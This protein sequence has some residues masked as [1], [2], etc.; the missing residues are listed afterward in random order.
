M[1]RRLPR[2]PQGYEA[3]GADR[4]LLSPFICR[5]SNA[6]IG[7]DR[8]PGDP[9]PGTASPTLRHRDGNRC[10]VF[11]PR[12]PRFSLSPY[13]ASVLAAGERPDTGHPSLAVSEYIAI[14]GGLDPALFADAF[15]RAAA[16]TDALRLRF[17]VT[18]GAVRRHLDPGPAPA[19]RHLDL[20]GEPGPWAAATAWLEHEAARLVAP[21]DGAGLY[22][23]ALITLGPRLH[24]WAHYAHPL[25]LDLPGLALLRTRVAEVYTALDDGRPVPP[26][27]FAPI[28]EIVR[29]EEEIRRG[30]EFAADRDHWLARHPR[31]TAPAA[32]RPPARALIRHHRTLPVGTRTALRRSAADLG[33]PPAAPV[34]AAAALYTLRLGAEGAAV[35]GVVAPGHGRSPAH[36]TPAALA[37][38]LHV[39]FEPDP[40]A[41]LADLV[42][43]AAAEYAAADRHSRYGAADLDADLLRSGSGPLPHPLITLATDEHHVRFGRNHGTVHVLNPGTAG[44]LAAVV[45][46]GLSLFADPDRHD[47]AALALHHRRLRTLL[48]RIVTQPGRRVAESDALTWAERRPAVSG[49]RPVPPPPA[50]PAVHLV[51]QRRVKEAPHATAVVR[52]DERLTY[53]EL[54]ARANQLAHRLVERG[55]RRGD[56][57][58][59]ALPRSTD[60]V[61]AVLAV[62]KAGACY[63]PLDLRQPDA[64]LRLVLAE[65]GAHTVVTDAAAARHPAAEGRDV[66]AIDGPWHEA[67][68]G[69]P[70]VDVDPDDLAYV[71]YTSGST[72]RPKGIGVPHRAV[73]ALAADRRWRGGGHRRV[74]LHSPHSFDAATYELWTPLLGG[75][76]AVIAPPGDLGPAELRRTI[77]EGGAT[78]A[79]VT[80][81]L[82][83]V[84]ADELP[85]CFAGMREVW[86]GGDRVAPRSC[87]RVLDHCPGLRVVNVYGPTETTTFALSHP[88]HGPGLGDTV[89]IGRPMDDTRAHVLDRHLCPVPDGV[90]G[91]LYLAGGGLAR[92]YL[93]APGLTAERFVAD[94]FGPPGTRMYRT[95]DV[96]RRGA[97]GE[98][99]FLGRVDDQV[100]IRGFRI[101]PGE[102]EAALREHPGVAHAAVTVR[103]DRPGDRQLVGYIVAAD[104]GEHD[105]GD[106]HVHQVTEWQRI[107]DG[108]YGP[109]PDGPAAGPDAPRAPFGADFTGWNSSYDGRPIPADH[110][111]EWRDA[112]VDRIRELRPRRVLEIGVGTGLLLARL[113]PDC[114]EY[115]GTDFSAPAIDALRRNVDRTPG[116]AGRVHLRVGAADDTAGLPAGRFD[117]IVVNSVVQYF[118]NGG[119]LTDVLRRAAGL[120]APGGAI[121][122]GDVRDLRLS[123][124][125]HTETTL[126]RADPVDGAAAL[127]TAVERHIAAEQELMVDPCYFA[128]LAAV[129]P[130]LTGADVRVKRGR[131]HNEMSQYRYD[132]V[133][134]TAAQGPPGPAPLDLV[135]GADVTG[136]G[137]LAD[138]LAERPAPHI[139]L[140]GVPNARV[141]PAAA[142]WRAL[143]EE[144][145]ADLA[146]TALE[147]P[148]P[149]V[150]DPEDLYEAARRTGHRT[151][152][153][154]AGTPDGSLDVHF[155]DPREGPDTPPASLYRPPGGAGTDPARHTNSPHLSRQAGAL[156]ARVRTHLAER[157]PD[158]MV[159]RHIMALE[160]LP[161][162]RNGKVDRAALPAPRSGAVADGRAPRTPME[163]RLCALFAEILGAPS[164]TIDDD[165]F[166]LGGHSLSATRLA[167][168]IR[169]ALGI[170]LPVRA[171]FEAP[172]VADLVHRLGGTAARGALAPRPRPDRLPLSHAQARLW[173]LYRLEGPTATYNVP[174]RVRLSGRLDRDALRAA[175]ADVAA[176]HESLRTV[177]ADDGGIPHQVVLDGARP[178][179]TFTE[180]TPGDLEA[181]ADQAARRPFAIDSEPPIRAA[182]F[183]TA[184][185]AHVLVLVLHHIACDG[186]S[187]A[188]LGRDLATAYAARTA[189]GAPEWPP[190]PVQYADYTLWQRD[191]LGD[192][193]G[194][195]AGRQLDHW[196]RT[197]DG[198]P[199]RIALP[200]DRPHPPVPAHHGDRVRF[201]ITAPLHRALTD[202]AQSHGA[203][204][205]MVLHA[206][207]AALLTR[208]GA[209]TDIPI[210]SPIAGRTDDALDDLV[211][212]FV[213]TLVLRT[214][215]SGDPRFRDLL[216]RV[217]EVAL[218][219]HAH[220]DL[221][222]ERLVEEIRPARSLAH[223]PLFQV[224]LA[225]QNAPAVGRPQPG[226]TAE[227]DLMGTGT[228]RFDLVLSLTEYL[229]DD[230]APLGL[231]GIAEFGTA[232]FDRAT[233]DALVRRLIRLLDSAAADPGRRIGD[234][235]VLDPDERHRTLETWND[236]ARDLPRVPYP[237]LFDSQAART[238]GAP[239]LTHADTT[240]TYGE[241]SARANRLARALIARG[242]GPER[243]VAIAL[244]RSADQV[245]ALLAVLA[246][247]A[248]Y[249]PLDPGQPGE[250]L[251]GMLADTR[252][253]L[254]LGTDATLAGLPAADAPA[255]ALDDIEAE[256]AG[257]PA[258]PVADAE[259][260]TPLHPAHPAYTIFT[261]GSTGR[262]KGVVV[263]HTGLP[264]LAAANRERFGVTPDSRVLQFAPIGFDGAVWEILGAL[265]AGAT[266]VSAAADEIAPG[267]GLAGLA[268]RRR[269]THATLPPAVLAAMDPAD[270]PGV[271]SIISSG[272]ELPGRLAAAWAPG[273]RLINGYGPTETTVCATLS[274]PLSGDGPP[275]IG[276][277][278]VDARCYVLDD[279]LAPMPPGAAGELYVAGPGLARG[280]L[281]RPGLTAARFVAD[282]FGRP[283]TRMYRTGDLARWTRSG[284]LEFVG[285]ADDQVKIR[286]FR[287]EPGEVAAVL[288]RHPAVGRAA[289]VAREDRPG[290][291]RLVAY[292]VP[293]PDADPADPAELRRH[294]AAHLPGYLTPAAVV[295]L[296]A[297]PTLPSGKLDKAALPAPCYG[298]AT[299]GRPPRTD[300]EH[301]LCALFADV[302][303]LSRDQVGADDGFFDLG[304]HSL[305]V[306]RLLSGVRDRTGADL[307][308]RRLFELQTVAAIAR[309]AA[310]AA[311]PR[312]AAGATR[313]DPDPAVVLAADAVLDPRIAIAAAGTAD[314]DRGA[315]PEHI[316]LTGATGFLGAALLRELLDRTRA[317]VH[318]LVRAGD[319]AGG[320]DRIRRNMLR[321]G[322]GPGPADGARITAVPGDLARPLLG[323]TEERF[324]ELAGRIDVIYHNGARVSAVEPYARLRSHNV[325]GTREVI[326]LAARGRA[327]P[328]HFVSTAAVAVSR[329]DNPAVLTEDRR[330][331]ATAVLP[332]G[333][334]AGKWVAEELLGA[335]AAHGLPVTV[336]RPGRISGHSLTGIGGTDDTL[337]HLVRAMV[338]LGAVPESATRDGAVVDLVP[339]DHVA[340]MVVRISRHPGALGRTHHLTCP[341]PVP[342]RVLID[343]L[344]AGGHELRALPDS[345]WRELLAQ[346][347]GD[348]APG[349]G[350][351]AAALLSDVLP[352]VFAFGGLRFDR[353]NADAGLTGSGIAAPAVDA[354]LL[355]RYVGH[356]TR[357]GFF[358]A[359]ACA[360]GATPAAARHDL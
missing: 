77:T 36:R 23:H 85:D 63:V 116:L 253:V 52:G 220:Q 345:G 19:P 209:G 303:G 315:D 258:T 40:G 311:G 59:I 12:S 352:T 136:P 202:L 275:P 165:F 142:A 272:E 268:A 333:Y 155:L 230:G 330:P 211:G 293:A 334:V 106:A 111:H 57:V 41:P 245:A 51:F 1:A 291:R 14:S 238:P 143:H 178:E 45:G 66:L 350:L 338:M 46:D 108:L 141:A 47:P 49:R 271:S 149:G 354:G 179:F 177:M 78:A 37:A 234:L 166:D 148:A 5:A 186:W 13:Q 225:L 294:A 281:G 327:V 158:H 113:A 120:L 353:R 163:E 208:L 67:D 200:T 10:Y 216:D 344:R 237:V 173:F 76:T 105:G 34:L 288:E 61:T 89:P 299:T 56:A 194:S 324:S 265:A 93:R 255:V 217:R 287:I 301:T 339:V 86:T 103:E 195:P 17:T 285:R 274:A 254:I 55:C 318:C 219:A 198:L 20:S 24:L 159:P 263:T 50:A 91:E 185:D 98:T 68:P 297:L 118:P 82:F 176:R 122:V 28:G 92:G 127:R 99:E 279:R 32:P 190:L 156:L 107:Y 284:H 329:N 343:A 175:L 125:F 74:L 349:T 180:T 121:F 286:G 97:D 162:T 347:A 139:R 340:R 342:F 289:V 246:S 94:P 133:L 218:A 140:V 247:G 276:R 348:H 64:R 73:A 325:H 151:V 60:L 8:R 239:A 280:Y 356:L 114:E 212:F 15:Q 233:I 322:V 306:P 29:A 290:D 278:T 128:A 273:R 357:T 117:T 43:A 204:L 359:P 305:L 21:A 126:R 232:V 256:A 104:T 2:S 135:W 328:V 101:E 18:D 134:R 22:R 7:A 48:R 3:S 88:V 157:L 75:G 252:P 314:P 228:C 129:V 70:P 146:R 316:L 207:F 346:R 309:E 4:A 53:A 323:L 335:A 131:R 33:V 30:P 298:P 251:G 193:P 259:R 261:S 102:V 27:G 11:D 221:P 300:L 153:T 260:T 248:G 44:E 222:F 147:R 6:A 226:M 79:F 307:T 341:D 161:L 249:L 58:A 54:N 214:D 320:A 26:S 236:T 337:W 144:G 182:L 267:H 331:P 213:N 130:G 224:M 240:W 231:G 332:S 292:V 283:G 250:R 171:V 25:L 183:R 62:L 31:R 206:G 160:R 164:V 312:G 87:R 123:R 321:H 42:R 154:W 310:A 242:A 145:D 205:F 360:P 80:S 308:V 115:W 313:T 189:G 168:R 227:I 210:G 191:L 35:V 100:K 84:I 170:E 269:V 132:A 39:P 336:H 138:L 119:Y 223:H 9:V 277:P 262:P 241:L 184:E 167:S 172:R 38:L 150:P 355:A 257:L 95:G 351:E 192:G 83:D 169:T 174:L 296:P 203:T 229:D 264:G 266:L 188:P 235:G 319:E 270:L 16:D 124:L 110:M 243:F 65:T 317:T 187:L 304:G 137:H 302:L 181:L 197:L 326:R 72:G 215:T 90:A 96:V 112:T 358:P 244:P 152:A 69:A 199:E 295:P 201:E 81:A 196:R 109:A 71:M 282:P